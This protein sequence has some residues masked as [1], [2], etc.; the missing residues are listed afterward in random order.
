[1]N[2]LM[3]FLVYII[4]FFASHMLI[5][6]TNFNV[7][8]GYRAGG[9]FEEIGT[10]IKLKLKETMS[11]GISVDW[12][13]TKNTSYELVYSHQESQLLSGT[14][15]S[16]VLIDLDV[17]YLHLGGIYLWPGNI[18]Q[19][20]LVGTFG[21]TYFKPRQGGYNSKLRGSIGFGLGSRVKL[22]ERLGL[23]FEA[24]GYSTIFNSGG[25]TLCGNTGCNIFIAS[26]ALWQSELKAG[27]TYKF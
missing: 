26:D 22:T 4:C 19:P 10:G 1:M 25:V 8:T 27:L 9:E 14:A 11:S 17:D 18:V 24:R 5:A 3:K 16:D 2:R 6:E 12:A 15:S 20:Y 13:E 7:F 23:M 21:V